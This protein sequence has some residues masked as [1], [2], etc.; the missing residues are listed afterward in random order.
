MKCLEGYIKRKADF[1]VGKPDAV[2]HV[3]PPHK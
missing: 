1:E 3:H 2:M